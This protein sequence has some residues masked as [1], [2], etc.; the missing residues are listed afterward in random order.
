MAVIQT[1]KVQM[2]RGTE[3]ELPGVIT[4]LSPLR[5][6]PGLDVGE[7]GY[8]VDTGRLF[9][10]HAPN[11][12]QINYKRNQFPYQN[13]EVLTEASTETLRRIFGF[14]DRDRGGEAYYTALLTPGTDW[15]DVAIE[16]VSGAA[17]PY[18]FP[19]VDVIASIEYF[20]INWYTDDG[21]VHRDPLRQGTMRVLSQDVSEEAHISDEAVSMR[22]R[23]LTMPQAVEAEWAHTHV[24]FRVLRSGTIG[25]RYHRFQYLSDLDKPARLYFSVGRPTR[26]ASSP[27]EAPLMPG[28]AAAGPFSREDIEDIVGE[29]VTNNV[30]TRIKV[31]YKSCA[32]K[33]NF[34]VEDKRGF[35]PFVLRLSG[36]AR[37]ARAL[38]G[39]DQTLEVTLANSGVTA[40]TYSNPTV[41]VDAKGRVTSINNGTGGG[42][43]YSAGNLG[44]GIGTF[45]GTS[46]NRFNFRSLL[47]GSN[48]ALSLQGDDI[49][50]SAVVPSTLSVTGTAT[51][52]AVSEIN[53]GGALKV[54]NGNNGRAL[55][56]VDV[57]ANLKVSSNTTSVASVS[58][59]VVRGSATLSSGTTGQAILTVSGGGAV[60]GDYVGLFG[61]EE[62]N[63]EK[64][65]N[66][67]T[68]VTN[69]TLSVE[70]PDDFPFCGMEV[71]MRQP[72]G[73]SAYFYWDE[74]TNA[75]TAYT[76]QDNS[77]LVLANLTAARLNGRATSADRWATPRVVS[78]TGAVTGSALIDGSGD[79][80]ISVAS[81]GAGSNGTT[82]I[83]VWDDTAPVTTVATTLDFIGSGVSVSASGNRA[84]ITIPGTIGHY[85]S[86]NAV[87]TFTGEI[88]DSE[89]TTPTTW[90]TVASLSIPAGTSERRSI[91]GS[92]MV[93]FD[94][95]GFRT[96][97]FVRLTVN[98]VAVATVNQPWGDA[99]SGGS[100]VVD[101]LDTDNTRTGTLAITLDVGY[102]ALNNGAPQ[103]TQT[104]QV[105]NPSL[106]VL[107]YR[108]E[109]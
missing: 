21:R 33:L 20:L 16:R 35:A 57:P 3:G 82:Q 71:P 100:L 65:F 101:Y 88:L 73:A 43:S 29:M 37:G 99:N 102:L 46:G 105:I 77:N 42:A 63:G 56:T 66:A 32:R 39:F 62:V 75:F 44:T 45:D 76:G 9:V 36:D 109:S 95:A 23:D 97:R 2:R 6:E 22:R 104:Y 93:G 84:S 27:F 54:T 53:F 10:G 72:V 85:A 13:I 87:Q 11:L 48:V 26:I 64:T 34:E 38:D 58:E 55:V 86:S 60:S 7:L 31:D 68:R 106:K 69:G 1:S 19:G 50:V 80:S 14:L 70:T 12:G 4:S 15:Q 51:V 79:V 78:I 61:D 92:A 67:T 30:E 89:H 18:R 98:G 49:V 91:T 47:A 74:A 28:S 94:V 90:N 81:A 103:Y 8:A 17:V 96:S 41:T 25:D 107:R 40:G 83:A 52:S 59:I 5:F 24:Q 108:G